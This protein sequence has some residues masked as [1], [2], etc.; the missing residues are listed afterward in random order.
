MRVV[1]I[2]SDS[3]QIT[4]V[5]LEDKKLLL[6]FDTSSNK[7]NWDDRFIEIDYSFHKFLEDLDAVDLVVV[8]EAIYRQ[9][10]RTT[11]RLSHVVGM[12]HSAC[13]HRGFN[14]IIIKPTVWKYKVIGIGKSRCNKD[15]VKRFVS[16]LYPEI[17]LDKETHYYD[18]LCI[19]LF[20][21]YENEKNTST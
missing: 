6:E 9:N 12:I 21:F 18:A 8:E 10:P 3:R 14:C 19:A 16:S 11:V 1:G 5:L 2:D 7:A 17:A 15:E 20:G 4:A 13:I